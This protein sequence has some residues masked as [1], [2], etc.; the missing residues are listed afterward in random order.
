[1]AKH[2]TRKASND[3]KRQSM[4]RTAKRA[5]KYA[6]A[7]LDVDYILSTLDRPLVRVA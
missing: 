5:M 3:G 4:A 7:E 1:M 6:T 2:G